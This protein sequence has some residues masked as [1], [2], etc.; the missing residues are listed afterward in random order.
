MQEAREL[1]AFYDARRKNWECALSFILTR[2]WFG[3]CYRV[4]DKILPERKP[5]PSGV[6]IAKASL[7]ICI[8][9]LAVV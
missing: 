4:Y 7:F 3:D 8:S 9:L 6:G 1:I 2:G 5:L